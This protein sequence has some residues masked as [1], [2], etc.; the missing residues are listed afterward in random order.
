MAKKRWTQ[1][2]FAVRLGVSRRTAIR[3]ING[4]FL[5]KPARLRLLSKIL[6]TLPQRLYP[7]YYLDYTTKKKRKHGEWWNSLVD[8]LIA[9]GWRVKELA[10]RCGISI[11]RA[12]SLVSWHYPPTRKILCRL[13][14]G[15]G[16]K[17]SEFWRD[18]EQQQRAHLRKRRSICLHTG[19]L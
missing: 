9:R 14:N 10:K 6:N 4:E 2:R 17:R 12:Y 1:E 7:E 5:P 18:W 3:Y 13:E 11:G 19:S 15:L 8:V 16:K